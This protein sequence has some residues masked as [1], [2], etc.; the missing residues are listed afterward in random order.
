MNPSMNPSMHQSINQ[1]RGGAGGEG[2]RSALELG[3]SSAE[4]G[5]GPRG[6][7]RKASSLAALQSSCRGR[8]PGGASWQP[9][10]AFSFSIL[11]LQVLRASNLE[12]RTPLQHR[13]G[14]ERRS[15]VRRAP[16]RPGPAS[17][18]ALRATASAS[19]A[20][21]WRPPLYLCGGRLQ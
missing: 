21:F 16:R 11:L 8:S 1:Y 10:L 18:A 5:V 14:P 4:T 15:A 20:L 19:M 9:F 6:S 3:S 12:P 7:L 13:R 17:P 2:N